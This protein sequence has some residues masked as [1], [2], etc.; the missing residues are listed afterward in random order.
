M[1]GNEPSSRPTQ[2]D[3]ERQ[4]QQLEYLQGMAKAPMGWPAMPPSQDALDPAALQAMLDKA[5]A[6]AKTPAKPW[7][8]RREVLV[9][10]ALLVALFLSLVWFVSLG[11]K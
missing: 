4:R 9:P 7:Y 8:R 2:A 10:I 1:S 5:A 6:E 3:V 11:M